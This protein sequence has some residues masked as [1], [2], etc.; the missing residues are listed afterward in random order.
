MI[1]DEGHHCHRGD[2]D[3]R[4]AGTTEHPVVRGH[5]ADTGRWACSGT[6]STC[7]RH[8]DLPGSVQPQTL[9]L[10]SVRLLPH[11][12]H[13]GRADQ[14]SLESQHLR[15]VPTSLELRDIFSHTDSKQATATSGPTITG[16]NPLLKEALNSLYRDYEDTAGGMAGAGPDRTCRSWPS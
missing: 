3:K 1:N 14:D 10:D 6:S 16:N 12:R 8:A 13:R 11:R 15:T 7:P 2:P 9:R 4:N 5:P